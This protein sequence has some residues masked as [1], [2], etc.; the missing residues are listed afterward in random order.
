MS[1]PRFPAWGA[2]GGLLLSTPWWGP[3]GG[4]SLV[5]VVLLGVPAVLMCA[6]CA[7]GV[8]ALAT[9]VHDGD[10]LEAGRSAGLTE[11]E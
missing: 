11:G 3:I 7:A 6:G 8:L 10:L 1:L 4:F 2:V 9:N 5:N